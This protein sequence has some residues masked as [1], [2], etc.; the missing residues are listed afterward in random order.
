[1]NRRTRIGLSG[2][3]LA[4]V[5]LLAGS[6]LAGRGAARDDHGAEVARPAILVFAA[7]SLTDVLEKLGADFGKSTG[8]GVKFVFAA[9]SV[10]ARQIEAGAPA[11]IFFSADRDWMDYLQTR[12][13]IQA[14]SRR[15]LLGNQLVL[16]APAA[17][18]LSLKIA[19]QFELAAALGGKGRLATGDPDSVPAGRYARASLTTLGVWNSVADRLVRAE[20]VRAALA[21]VERGEVPLG[22]VYRTDALSDKGVRIVDTFPAGSHPPITYPIALTVGAKSV[23][24]QFADYL[25][26]PAVGA[27]FVRYGFT[28][29]TL[30]GS[31]SP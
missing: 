11:D 4:A 30:E 13:L 10:L 31:P 28:A 18:T 25:G 17:S 15:D 5:M 12:K 26:K 24:A 1:M 9:S 29:L 16:V 8:I 6:A 14:E 2:H 3:A 21:F 7:A 20:N 27:V 19:P 22:I 23:A